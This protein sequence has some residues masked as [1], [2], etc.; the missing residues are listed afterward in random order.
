VIVLSHPVL[1]FT[2]TTDTALS[3]QTAAGAG[4]VIITWPWLERSGGDHL[5][6]RSPGISRSR[7]GAETSDRFANRSKK[8]GS[9]FVPDSSS[10]E[11]QL[12]LST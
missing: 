10:A 2:L 7:I 11:I 9:D 5:G 1:P 8:P 3:P 6:L 4:V 12:D